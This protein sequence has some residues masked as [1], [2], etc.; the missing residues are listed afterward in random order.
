MIMEP[1]EQP[2]RRNRSFKSG[3][4]SIKQGGELDQEGTGPPKQE[5]GSENH[6][7]IKEHAFGKRKTHVQVSRMQIWERKSSPTKGARVWQAEN[8]HTGFWNAD[9]GAEIIPD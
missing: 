3:R 5:S 6:P 8:S 7:R 1:V 4:V 2:S 9:M